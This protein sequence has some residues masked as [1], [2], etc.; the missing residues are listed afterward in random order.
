MI[1]KNK[2]LR[3]SRYMAKQMMLRKF[4]ETLKG[5]IWQYRCTSREGIIIGCWR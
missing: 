5:K 1:D 3:Y 2:K 4:S